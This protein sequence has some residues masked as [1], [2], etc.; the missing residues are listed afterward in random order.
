MPSSKSLAATRKAKYNPP[1]L[2]CIVP[3][4]KRFFQKSSGRTNHMNTAHPLF[5]PATSSDQ[6]ERSH[7]PAN[8]IELPIE[9]PIEPPQPLDDW[10]E[11]NMPDPD[12]PLPEPLQE[13][14]SKQYIYEYHPK[15]NGTFLAISSGSAHIQVDRTSMQRKWRF[16]SR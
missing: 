13:Q 6:A 12:Q 14:E 5:Y 2:P 4:C 3:G 11:Q 10:I 8:P 9:L 16:C 7:I 1:K 15:L